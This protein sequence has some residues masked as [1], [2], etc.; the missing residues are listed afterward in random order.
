MR[1]IKFLSL[2]SL[3]LIT[4]CDKGPNFA[5][6]CEQN[7]EI[8]QEFAEDSWCKKERIAVGFANLTQKTEPKDIHQFNQLIAYESFEKC[9]SHAAKIEHIKLKEKKT[10][11]INNMMLARERIIE[12]SDATIN[13]EHPRLLYYHWTRYLNKEAL[14]KFLALEGDERLETPESQFELATYYAKRDPNKTLAVLFHSLELIQLEQPINPEV[15]KSLSS[16][17]ADKGEN[18]QAYIWLKVLSLY[19]PD[20]ENISKDT[21][22]NYIRAYSL[23]GP[24][25][26][27]V[28]IATLEKIKTGTFKAPKF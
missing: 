8:C 10:K 16:I 2:L 3:T 17:F 26:D 28:A 27:R 7:P 6:L 4:A 18:K 20:D 21:L 12:I 5:S 22:T 1:Y 19:K 13:S 11:R 15:F 23:D 24:F 14:E 25:L 9:V